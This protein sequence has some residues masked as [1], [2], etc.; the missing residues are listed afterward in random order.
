MSTDVPASEPLTTSL[1]P[2]LSVHR[3]AEAV[4]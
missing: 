2:W 4:N 3:G 1:T